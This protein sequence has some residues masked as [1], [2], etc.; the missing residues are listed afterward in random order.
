MK[1]DLSRQRRKRKES[2]KKISGADKRIE[3]RK[4][5]YESAQ[6]LADK[7]TAKIISTA[8]DTVKDSPRQSSAERNEN[9]Q[10]AKKGRSEALPDLIEVLE[11][12]EVSRKKDRNDQQTPKEVTIAKLGPFKMSLEVK[13][14]EDDSKS[15]EKEQNSRKK[16]VSNTANPAATQTQRRRKR[17]RSKSEHRK[18][19]STVDP[20]GSDKKEDNLYQEITEISRESKTETKKTKKSKDKIVVSKLVKSDRPL[21]EKSPE[22]GLKEGNVVKYAR[23]VSQPA[24]P[25]NFHLLL[26]PDCE[27][28]LSRNLSLRDT[29]TERQSKLR[30]STTSTTAIASIEE[31][32]SR[33]KQTEKM[34]LYDNQGFDLSPNL[35][36]KVIADKKQQ[37]YLN[38]KD[39]IHTQLKMAA[40]AASSEAGTLE[41]TMERSRRYKPIEETDGCNDSDCSDDINPQS[42]PTQIQSLSE[43]SSGGSTRRKSLQVSQSSDESEHPLSSLGLVHNSRQYQAEDSDSDSDNDCNLPVSASNPH[44]RVPNMIQ[45]V[46]LP[47]TSLKHEQLNIDPD[48]G[49]LEGRSKVCMIILPVAGCESDATIDIRNYSQ[50]SPHTEDWEVADESDT[51]G[52]AQQM[53]Y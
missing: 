23:S 51:D 17:S 45:P 38:L 30:R 42:P 46:P 43:E 44:V 9:N 12:K 52:I 6:A 39:Q 10:K 27:P 53:M 20:I 18:K 24:P 1:D 28:T 50:A 49:L 34:S 21:R 41:R 47:R 33:S 14:N 26:P 16:K 32:S 11:D 37:K 15:R 4:R 3:D 48:L 36:R 35:D 40:A 19:E 25:S 2:S 29:D 31:K 22:K 5:K 8:P 7:L 13:K